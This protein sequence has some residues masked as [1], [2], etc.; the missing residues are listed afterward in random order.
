MDARNRF[1]T[2]GTWFLARLEQLGLVLL[3]LTLCVVQ[4]HAIHWGRFIASFVVIDLV[5]YLPGAWASR[6]AGGAGIAPI[7]HHLYNLTHS[8]LFAGV[9]LGTWALLLGAFEPAM[10]AIPLHLAGDRALFGNF[11]K[12]PELPFEPRAV[13]PSQVLP[14]P[15][16]V[17]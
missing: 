1:H 17:S 13:D 14:A 4:S 16:E 2:P 6:R 9:V 7:Y 15:K 5:G 8:Y 3:L 11:S 12:P 10:A